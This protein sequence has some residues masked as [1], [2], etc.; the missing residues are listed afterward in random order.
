MWKSFLKQ[1]FLPKEA[2]QPDAQ[3]VSATHFSTL[4]SE[5]RAGAIR[6][7]VS[8]PEQWSPGDTAILKSQEDIGS[9]IFETPIQH[10]YEAGVEVRS[11]PPTERLEEMEGR[12]VVDSSGNRYVK[13]WLTN[14]DLPV[15]EWKNASRLLRAV[16]NCR[17]V[18]P[19]LHRQPF[20]LSGGPGR[21]GGRSFA[22]FTSPLLPRAVSF[23][24]SGSSL[25]QSRRGRKAVLPSFRKSRL[26]RKSF[27]LTRLSF[28]QTVFRFLD[29]SCFLRQSSAPSGS[30]GCVGSLFQLWIS[31]SPSLLQSFDQP[32]PSGSSSLVHEV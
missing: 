32:L 18:L 30:L 28:L 31:T 19:S 10:D 29:Q 14:L 7:D 3:P 1:A 5:V 9:L 6:A 23:A 22:P 13:F 15:E 12:W 11:L 27:F 26:R 4:R 20:T 21:G 24:P 17:L 2:P 16:P 8:N 25:R